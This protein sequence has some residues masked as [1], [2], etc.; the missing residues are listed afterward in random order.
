VIDIIFLVFSFIPVLLLIFGLSL[1]ISITSAII[2]SYIFV[3]IS[4][5]IND[6]SQRA[7]DR[8]LYTFNPSFKN[9][10]I[11]IFLWPFVISESCNGFLSFLANIIPRMFGIP[12]QAFMWFMIICY[13]I[14]LT[15]FV[16]ILICIGLTFGIFLV[17]IVFSVL[18]NALNF[19]IM[20][21][22][23]KI[24]SL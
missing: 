4:Q 11:G 24:E 10:V 17:A 5:T 6:F 13:Y 20:K 19:I 23:S 14:D 18:L 21:M 3:G 16:K 2:L 15:F 9:V 8:P 1:W 22:I 12:F 7:I